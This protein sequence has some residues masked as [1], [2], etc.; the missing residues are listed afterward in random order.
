[1]STWCD[2]VMWLVVSFYCLIRIGWE[3]DAIYSQKIV[4]FVNKS[5]KSLL[6]ARNM[7][8]KMLRSRLPIQKGRQFMLIWS[9]QVELTTFST[10]PQS[11]VVLVQ[12]NFRYE[13]L[14]ARETIRVNR[15]NRVPS[16]F[17]THPQSQVVLNIVQY[18]DRFIHGI[19]S[20]SIVLLRSLLYC[21]VNLLLGGYNTIQCHA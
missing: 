1:M 21:I 10:H 11:T 20:Y 2:C 18:S 12:I 15:S 7:S 16:T 19:V 4:R 8:P 3:K 5:H 14:T 17:P 6:W 9:N 13:E